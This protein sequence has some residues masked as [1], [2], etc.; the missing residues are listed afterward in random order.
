MRDPNTVSTGQP[1]RALWLSTFSF[2]V[3]F[4]FWTAFSIIGVRIKQQLGLNETE[5]GLLIA[6][7]YSPAL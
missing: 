1:Q 7:P 4:A 2:A 6:T 3:C 5:F